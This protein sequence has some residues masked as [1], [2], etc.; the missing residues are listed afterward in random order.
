MWLQHMTSFKPFSILILPDP[1]DLAGLPMGQT[2]TRA[3]WG[4]KVYVILVRTSPGHGQHNLWLSLKTCSPHTGAW[5]VHV[6]AGRG[7]KEYIEDSPVDPHL[8]YNQ[9]NSRRVAFH[10]T[11]QMS[12]RKQIPHQEEDKNLLIEYRSR[13]SPVRQEI[14]L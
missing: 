12:A 4:Y 13:K 9:G 1:D 11:Q 10:S 6:R 2:S 14:F 8:M 5:T 7:C 3:A